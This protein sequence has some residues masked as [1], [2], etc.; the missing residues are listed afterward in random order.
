MIM[1]WALGVEDT[2]RSTG[3]LDVIEPIWSQGFRSWLAKANH[4]ELRKHVESRG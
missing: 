3:W 4:V 1:G 2:L